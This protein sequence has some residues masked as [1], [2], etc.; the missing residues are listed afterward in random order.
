MLTVYVQKISTRPNTPLH[1]G[2][3]G[4]LPLDSDSRPQCE[5]AEHL[6]LKVKGAA[7]P[8]L[9]FTWDG[10]SP[11]QCAGDG[12][13][14]LHK[15]RGRVPS[16]QVQG[17]AIILLNG[18]GYDAHLHLNAKGM[19]TFLFKVKGLLILLSIGDGNHS[20]HWERHGHC[21]VNAKGEST[22]VIRA[23]AHAACSASTGIK[24]PCAC[25][26]IIAAE[27]R[28]SNDFDECAVDFVALIG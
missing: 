18:K 16:L 27:A 3:D 13:A 11:P 12:H 10:N 1:I 26:E 25:F 28:N 21:P 24:S 19:F 14:P 17:M 7:I 5:G 22:C 2:W 20:F 6:P 9:Q 8:L 4:H 23:D 15:G